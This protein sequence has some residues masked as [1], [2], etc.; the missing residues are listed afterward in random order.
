M[1][2]D[3]KTWLFKVIGEYA[4]PDCFKE[5]ITEQDDI[6][7]DLGFD[8][9]DRTDLWARIDSR[10][11]FVPTMDEELQARSVGDIMQIIDRHTASAKQE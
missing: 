7:T 1:T 10:F 9:I 4:A 11:F 2:A 8:S 5:T 6:F 3:E